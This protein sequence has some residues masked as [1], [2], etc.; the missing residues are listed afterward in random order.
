MA[1][2]VDWLDAYRAGDIEAILRMCS[3][4]TVIECGC[5]GMKVI[6]GEHGVRAYWEQRLRDYPAGE[7]E[8]L[9]TSDS[10]A[11]VLY[12]CGDGVVA[13]TLRF[14]RDG[15]IAELCCGPA[16]QSLFSSD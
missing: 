10:G 13:A 11:A 4:D 14:D 5:G 7:L 12:R 15:R 2:A 8:D 16:S 6:R 3:N 9:Q 1:A